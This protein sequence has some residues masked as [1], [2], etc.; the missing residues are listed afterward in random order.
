MGV[1]ALAIRGAYLYAATSQT[2]S[3]STCSKNSSCAQLQVFSTADTRNLQLLE[4]LQ[5]STTSAPFA[6][7]TNGQ[8]TGKS[9]AVSFPYL[10]EG[11]TK[12][13]SP[14][15]DEFNIFSI[16]E[17]WHPVWIGGYHVG[18][19]VSSIAIRG[20]Y[21]YVATD[22]TSKELLVLDIHDPEH[23]TEFKSYNAPG[24]STYGYGNQVALLPAIYPSGEK[25]ITSVLLGRTYVPNQPELLSLS[26]GSTTTVVA[27]TLPGTP[28]HPTSIRDLV[29]KDFLL[30]ALT[31]SDIQLLTITPTSFVPFAPSIPLQ[32]N[33]T[34]LACHDNSLYVGITDTITKTGSITVITPR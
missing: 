20:N 18:A 15:G 3:Y 11:L 8:A 22:D 17:G 34:T 5:L 30:F 7:G 32:G 21:A 26:I 23:I 13:G 24:S 6:T 29:M 12:M 10:Y 27:S 4:S 31:N 16:S 19:G 33:A 2:A 9:L 14:A 28:L 25:N 1:A